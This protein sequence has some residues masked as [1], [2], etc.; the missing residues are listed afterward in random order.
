MGFERSEQGVPLHRLPDSRDA[1]PSI[2][3][4]FKAFRHIV[5]VSLV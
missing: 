3:K 4:I 5:R 2:G 1:I